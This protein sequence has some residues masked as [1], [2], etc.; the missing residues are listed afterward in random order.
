MKKNKSIIIYSIIGFLIIIS[1][2]RK[3]IHNKEYNS[4]IENYQLTV[5]TIINITSK[6]KS[7]HGYLIHYKFVISTDTLENTTTALFK[8]GQANNIL[9]KK[10]LIAYQKD[11]IQNNTILINSKDFENFRMKIPDSLKWIKQAEFVP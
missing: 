7:L 4:I 6:S 5:G 11:K 9:G 10:I 2:I 1:L 3:Y 8:L